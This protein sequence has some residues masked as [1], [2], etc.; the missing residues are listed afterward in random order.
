MLK[1]SRQE[2]SEL[3]LAVDSL[4]EEVRVLRDVLDEIREAL[5][6]QNNN[7]QDFPALTANRQAAASLADATLPSPPPP[8]EINPVQAQPPYS[9]DSPSATQRNLF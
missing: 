6:W 9:A 4:R 1:P 3:T 7:A 8:V 5:Q 2:K